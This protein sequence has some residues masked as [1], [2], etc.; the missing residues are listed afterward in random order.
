MRSGKPR[1]IPLFPRKL[2]PWLE[3]PHS[4]VNVAVEPFIANPLVGFGKLQQVAESHANPLPHASVRGCRNTRATGISFMNIRVL[5]LV[6]RYWH[7]MFLHMLYCCFTSSW[8][9]HGSGL[10]RRRGLWATLWRR[11]WQHRIDNIIIK[12]EAVFFTDTS[13]LETT[14]YNS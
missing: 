7:R 5:Q 9:S 10:L 12:E 2:R 13:G 8:C 4:L 6:L 3:L 11:A 1:K 14:R